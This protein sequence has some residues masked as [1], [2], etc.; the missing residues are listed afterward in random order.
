MSKRRV[1]IVGV[2]A[3]DSVVY[4]NSFPV[5]G[6]FAAASRW[7]ERPGGSPGNVALALATSS[8]ETGLV[9]AVGS[10]EY[11]ARLSEVIA[12][13]DLSHREIAEFEGASTRALVLVEPDGDRTIVGAGDHHDR[14]HLSDAYLTPDD[15]VVFVGWDETFL[16]DLE[17]AKGLGCETIVGVSAL[18]DERVSGADMVFGSKSDDILGVDPARHLS[19]F[20]RIVLTGGADGATQYDSS[21]EV[22]RQP[23]LPAEVLDTTGAGDAFLAG[24][25]SL[26]ALG[27]ESGRF[28]LEAGAVWASRMI[29]IEASIPPPFASVEGLAEVELAYQLSRSQTGSTLGD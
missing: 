18:R 7:I 24:Y 4:L 13:S 3:W 14:I 19:R 26:Y 27:D 12:R 5:P 8:I 11:G 20:N 17:L 2:I 1:W 29:S 10:D 16:P 6:Y 23:A 22:R 21:G 28:A 15:I 25:L 9:S